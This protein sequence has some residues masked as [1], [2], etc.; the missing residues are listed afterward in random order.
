MTQKP[1]APLE[2]ACRALCRF[3]NLSEDTKFEGRPMWESYIPEAAAV[4]NALG[5][6]PVDDGLLAAKPTK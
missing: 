3:H 4:L 6:E 1:K 2:L 5:I